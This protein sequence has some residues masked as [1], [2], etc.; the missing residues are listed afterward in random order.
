MCVTFPKGIKVESTATVLISCACEAICCVVSNRIPIGAVVNCDERG[1][2]EWQYA[3]R[4]WTIAK[5]WEKGTAAAADAAGGDG[6]RSHT[7][8]PATAA[9]AVSGIHHS[10]RPAWRRSEERR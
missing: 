5:T 2:S 1:W 3:H 7:A 6:G 9:A 8:S 10:V 4:S